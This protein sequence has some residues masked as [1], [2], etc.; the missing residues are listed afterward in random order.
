MESEVKRICNVMVGEIT[1]DAQSGME[2]IRCAAVPTVA[3]T[4]PRVDC[5]VAAVTVTSPRVVLVRAS[6]RSPSSTRR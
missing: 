2:E 4:T 3:T 5:S 6:L 1:S